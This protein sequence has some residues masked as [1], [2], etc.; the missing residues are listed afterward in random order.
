MTAERRLLSILGPLFEIGPAPLDVV[1]DQCADLIAV[2]IDSEK[3][4]AFLYE[5]SSESLVAVGTSHTPLAALQRRTGLNR[6]AIANGDPMS[7][8]YQTGESYR[9]G[10]TDQDPTQPRGVIETLGV[11]SMAAAPIDVAGVRRGV[12]SLASTRTDAFSEDDLALVRIVAA[13]VGSLVHRAELLAASAA[14]AKADGRRA[15]GDELV[16]VLAHDVR[17]LLHPIVARVSLMRDRASDEARHRE[18][19]EA[20]RVLAGLDRLSAVVTDLLDVARLDAGML[21]LSRERVELVAL[22]RATAETLRPPDVEVRVDSYCE[23]LHIQLDGARLRQ[24]VENVLSNAIKHS[25][26]AS[27]VVITIEPTRTTTQAAAKIVIS[28]QGPGIRPDLLPR[29]FDRFVAGERSGGLGLGLYLARAIV[30]A[31]GGTIEVHSVMGQGT[32]C[33]LMLPIPSDD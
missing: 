3:V 33:E 14:R 22:M 27:A 7:R 32:R 15:A 13:W 30:A 26:R 18:V 1:L 16:T 23:Q 5:A 21:A 19:Q 9:S 4:D 2:G 29:I 12:L 20:G 11:R 24:A 6:L 31:H 17:N 8:V 10:H 25:P 28:D